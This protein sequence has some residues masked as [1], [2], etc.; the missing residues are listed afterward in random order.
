MPPVA[1]DRKDNWMGTKASTLWDS[2]SS[3]EDNE[4]DTNA[5]RFFNQNMRAADEELSKIGELRTKTPPVP[6]DSRTEEL[7][8]RQKKAV[9]C[10]SSSAPVHEENLVESS[11]SVDDFECIAMDLDSPK[12]RTQLESSENHHAMIDSAANPSSNN[13]AGPHEISSRIRVSTMCLSF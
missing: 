3:E 5:R 8:K 12:H 10:H 1:N 6:V 7:L 4:D 9:L 13:R 2:A 11:A